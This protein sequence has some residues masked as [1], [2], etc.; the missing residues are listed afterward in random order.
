MR[1]RTTKPEFW[2]S[3]DTAELDMFTRLLFIGLWNYVDDNGV[4]EDE[5]NLI[6]SD[7]FPRDPIEKVEPLIQRALTELSVKGQIVRYQDLKSRRRYL[8]VVN[9]H[10][11]RINRPTE[12][13]KPLP[14][15]ENMQLIEDSVSPH[16]EVTEDS[17][18]YQGSKGTRERGNEVPP[19]K[20]ETVPDRLPATRQNDGASVVRAKFS[21]LPAY[22][23][24]AFQIAQAFSASL[25]VPIQS[26]LLSQVAVQFESCL[27]DGIPPAAIAAGV[28]AWALSSSWHPNNIPTFVTKEAMK[29]TRS[30]MGKPTE[31]AMG[32]DTAVQQL[33]EE[34]AS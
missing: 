19:A 30:G 17:L 24:A 5:I 21:N 2:R 23:Q 15:S 1:I 11:Q 32:Y 29:H 16:G 27:Q 18:P 10:H 34:L 7:L 20:L 6:R 31:K 33:L 9:W 22:S 12:S 3:L 28:R 13:K 14:T 4:G 8:K 26:G 25:P